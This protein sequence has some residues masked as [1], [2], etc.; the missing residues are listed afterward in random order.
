M[1]HRG[2]NLWVDDRESPFLSYEHEI[3]QKENYQCKFIINRK[4]SVTYPEDFSQSL[5]TFIA[6][7]IQKEP[8]QR[9]SI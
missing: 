8:D 2:L 4:V 9:M 1:V 3:N 5:Q 7:L 6:S